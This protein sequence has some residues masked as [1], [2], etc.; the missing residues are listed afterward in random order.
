MG[1]GKTRVGTVL[2][3]RLG[4]SFIDTDVLIESVFSRPVAVIFSR[5]GEASFRA[6]EKKVVESVAKRSQCVVATG[7]GVVLDRENVDRL[8]SGGLL[9]HLT[10]APETIYDRIGHQRGRPLL[11]T[12]APRQTLESLFRIRETLYS[13]YSDFTVDRNSL[14]VDETVETILS[15]VASRGISVK[16]EGE[17][18][19]R[20]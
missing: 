2:A 18:I 8:K 17:K 13:T 1:V 4:W 3:N 9:V 15:M 6:T 7:G 20:K 11:E 5:H 10:M 19:G 14:G 12:E 16:R